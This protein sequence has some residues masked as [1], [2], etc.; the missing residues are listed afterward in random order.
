MTNDM[1]SELLIGTDCQPAPPDLGI[2]GGMGPAATVNFLRQLGELT[3]AERDQDHLSYVVW[4]D[5]RIPD[6]S[7]A[8]LGNGPSPLPHLRTAVTALV[9]LGVRLI[10]IPCNTAH[11]WIDD[12][13]AASA[14]PIVDM[15]SE[16]ARRT[17]ALHPGAKVCILATLGTSASPLY[18]DRLTAN[19]LHHIPLDAP[20]QDLVE[21]T[22][23]AVKAHDLVAAQ[24]RLDQFDTLVA[25]HGADAAI[26]AC[27]DLSFL[28]AE[29]KADLSV[30]M[31]DASD[32]LARSCLA[33]FGLSGA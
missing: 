4:G 17:A 29:A 16:T 26:V 14:V 8:L 19:G 7:A 20:S 9:G 28:I 1:T 2:V 5:P 32:S 30:P 33:H 11:H 27:T 3:V 6:R 31:V 15:I 10:A 18:R 24:H 13:S 23:R 22:I 21:A 25:Q 12:L